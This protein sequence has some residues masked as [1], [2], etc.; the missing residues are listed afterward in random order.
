MF[1]LC[2]Y[3]HSITGLPT[4]YV[5]GPHIEIS[6]CIPGLVCACAR[7]GPC[8]CARVCVCVCA[9]VHVCAINSGR[10]RLTEG[11]EE[12]SYRGL[13]LPMLQSITVC[14]LWGR[15]KPVGSLILLS[16]PWPCGVAA[17]TV[18]NSRVEACSAVCVGSITCMHK[19]STSVQPDEGDAPCNSVWGQ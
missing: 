9:Y 5:R 12:G 7:T 19:R 18:G 1:S 17:Q 3:H 4:V 11:A 13:Y 14:G 10:E 8:A 2:T 16:I 6:V 15:N